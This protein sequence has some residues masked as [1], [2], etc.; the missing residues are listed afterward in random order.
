MY[1]G[2]VSCPICSMFLCAWGTHIQPVGMGMNQ[3]GCAMG[4][5][6]MD[7]CEE[8]YDASHVFVVLG[9]HLCKKHVPGLYDTGLCV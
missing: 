1:V 5:Y 7:T 8:V 9:V 3:S 4:L 6:Y 2:C